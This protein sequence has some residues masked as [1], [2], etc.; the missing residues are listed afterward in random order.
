[1]GAVCVNAATSRRSLGRG[2]NFRIVGKQDVFRE[3]PMD[4]FTAF[5]KFLP[6]PRLRMPQRLLVHAYYGRWS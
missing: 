2:R 6:L 5:L 1:M 4:G 3:A